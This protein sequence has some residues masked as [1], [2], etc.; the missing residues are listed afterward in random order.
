[1]ASI[2]TYDIRKHAKDPTAGD[3]KKTDAYITAFADTTIASK[4]QGY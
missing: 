4:M 1:M 2:A 3:I